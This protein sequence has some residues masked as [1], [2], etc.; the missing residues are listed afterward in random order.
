MEERK[1]K[2]LEFSS[3]CI[4]EITKEAALHGTVFKPWAEKILED[5]AESLI[6]KTLPDAWQTSDRP[7]K[8]YPLGTKARAIGGGHW[9]KNERG[10]KWFNGSTFSRPGGDWDGMISLSV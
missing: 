6:K 8:D 7:L 10:W 3:D 4:R 5:H 1:F 9:I 2:N